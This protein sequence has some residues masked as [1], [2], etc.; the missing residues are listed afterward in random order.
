M[1]CLF[2]SSQRDILRVGVTLAG[3]Q[4]KILNSIQVMRAQM[5]QIQSVEVWYQRVLMLRFLEA[6]LPFAPVCLSS[7]SWVFCMDQRQ[8]AALRI[9]ATGRNALSSTMNSLQELLEFKQWK[10]GTTTKKRQLF[11][12]QTDRQLFLNN[13][14]AIAFLKRAPRPGVSKGRE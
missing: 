5:N 12:K 11:W 8:A 9:M 10:K 7:S 3:H 2:L 14:K 4:K 1:L 13:N 6:L